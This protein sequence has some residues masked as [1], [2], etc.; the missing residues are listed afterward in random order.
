MYVYSE[1]WNWERIKWEKTRV[2]QWTENGL[3]N[4]EQLLEDW[5]ER[6]LGEKKESKSGENGVYNNGRLEPI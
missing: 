4:N 6:E 5:T 1:D 3:C 2:S